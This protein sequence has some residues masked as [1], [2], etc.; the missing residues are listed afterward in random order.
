MF[1]FTFD[2]KEL[3]ISDLIYVGDQ[4][5]IARLPTQELGEAALFYR[6]GN[7]SIEEASEI[8]VRCGYKAKSIVPH[9][10]QKIPYISLEAEYG[11]S[12]SKEGSV[13]RGPGE[14]ED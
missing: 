11:R 4:I 7:P 9:Y 12:E 14:E 3:D 6:N 13:Q 2:G 5:V 1:T 10:F 8:V